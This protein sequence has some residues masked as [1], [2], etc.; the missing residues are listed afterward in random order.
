M[1]KLTYFQNH[2]RSLKSTELINLN[3]NVERGPDL[4]EP[5]SDAC[6][7]AYEVIL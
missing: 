3:G 6:I 7:M 2:L 4:I 1:S 5:L